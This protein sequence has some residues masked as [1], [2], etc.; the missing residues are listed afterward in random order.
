MTITIKNNEKKYLEFTIRDSDDNIMDL[1]NCDATIQLQKYGESS[2]S[3]ST[4]CTI[5]DATGGICKYLYNGSLTTGMYKAEIEIINGDTIY[6]TP[7]F[8]IDV[9]TSLPE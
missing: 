7:T 3:V 5:T 8:D 6:I 9:V 1:T 4:S 2:L